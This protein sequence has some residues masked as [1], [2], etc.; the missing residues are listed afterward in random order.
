MEIIHGLSVKEGRLDVQLDASEFTR[1]ARGVISLSSKS[2]G[3]GFM[4]LGTGLRQDGG[5][6]SLSISS[7]LGFTEQG[8]LKVSIGSSLGYDEQGVLKVPIGSGLEYDTQGK[9][10][11]KAGKG[12]TIDASNKLTLD[13]GAGLAFSGSKVVQKWN[14]KS[15]VPSAGESNL[16]NG[17]YIR[18]AT[19][20]HTA[21]EVTGSPE[22]PDLY[23]NGLCLRGGALSIKL[24]EERVDKS[25]G[26]SFVLGTSG[27][28]L[29]TM[30]LDIDLRVLA[31]A[32]APYLSTQRSEQ[33]V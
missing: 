17:L 16:Q 30:G 5:V 6:L 9:I 24:A 18:L 28:R 14:V 1:D 2:S 22:L 12:L 7:S 11:A 10:K 33:S 26:N 29:G 31:E 13:L 32:L 21:A 3:G 20:D 27:L 23:S 19:Q 15:P 25:D 8:Q 4:S